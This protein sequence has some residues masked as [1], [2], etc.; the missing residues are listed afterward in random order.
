M[1]WS[2][3]HCATRNRVQNTHRPEQDG[4]TATPP[5]RTM[6]ASAPAHNP[7]PSYMVPLAS[8]SSLSVVQFLITFYFKR[9][10]KTNEGCLR[11]TLCPGWSLILSA[12]EWFNCRDTMPLLYCLSV[13]L[14]LFH[15][16]EIGACSWSARLA[17]I[18]V[19]RTTFC[20]IAMN[21]C[22]KDIHQCVQV[23]LALS[24]SFE[25]RGSPTLCWITKK[26]D[27]QVSKCKANHQKHCFK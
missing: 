24:S 12:G 10:C 2:D 7:L 21:N 22:R 18:E 19:I 15:S 3:K 6:A 16:A 8:L 5:P 1:A 27:L 23:S 25:S 9:R 4:V 26:S 20:Y 13:P 14:N 11:G 17:T